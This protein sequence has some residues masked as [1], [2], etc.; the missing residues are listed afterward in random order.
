MLLDPA[1]WLV[2][3]MELTEMSLDFELFILLLAT[4]GFF[5]AYV[6]ERRMFPELARLV[7]RLKKSLLPSRQKRRKKYKEILEEM[8]DLE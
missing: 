6:A 7:G 5:V 2:D 4:G 3:F 8:Q 1:A